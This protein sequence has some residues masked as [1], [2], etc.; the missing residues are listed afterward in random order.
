MATQKRGVN[1]GFVGSEAYKILGLLDLHI[2]SYLLGTRYGTSKGL[3]KMRITEAWA[4]LVSKQS[5][6][7][8]WS[9]MH[10]ERMLWSYQESL[11]VWINKNG[12]EE[13]KT[14]SRDNAFKEFSYGERRNGVV[15]RSNTEVRRRFLF[16]LFSFATRWEYKSWSCSEEMVVNWWTDTPE[17]VQGNWDPL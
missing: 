13:M 7:W 3:L 10:V 6:L 15:A 2:G 11:L 8:W 4:L 1:P 12:R 5:R 16:L 14:E 9:L 17:L